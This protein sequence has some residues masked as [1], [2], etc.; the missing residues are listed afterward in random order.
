MEKAVVD[1][2]LIGGGAYIATRVIAM[3]VA[4]IVMFVLVEKVV[5][6][7]PH[8][9]PPFQPNMPPIQPL[10][11]GAKEYRQHM[12]ENQRHNAWQENMRSGIHGAQGAQA[13]HDYGHLPHYAALMA[14]N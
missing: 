9:Q 1:A 8:V 10:T 5:H 4:I 7:K 2:A 6:F 13:R 14:M 3:I 12:W 11:P